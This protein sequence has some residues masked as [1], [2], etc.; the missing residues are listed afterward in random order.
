MKRIHITLLGLLLCAGG[1]AQ[2]LEMFSE[3]GKK[4]FRDTD[5]NVVVP[6]KYHWIGP[7]SE[8]ARVVGLNGK[9]G[10]IYVKGKNKAGTFSDGVAEVYIAKGKKTLYIDKQGNEYKTQRAAKE[11]VRKAT[12][13]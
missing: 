13:K 3:D 2:E 8:G 4:G 7:F 12:G 9:F 6:A 10:C 1:Y 11:A 5:G